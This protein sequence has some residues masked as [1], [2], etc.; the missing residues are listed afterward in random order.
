MTG[1]V[2]PSAG[3]TRP[4]TSGA[5]APKTVGPSSTPPRISPMTGG[6]RYRA[7]SW[8]HAWAATSNAD[9]ARSSLAMSALG[10]DMTLDRLTVHAARNL[11]R[12]A[13]DEAAQHDFAQAVRRPLLVG[14]AVDDQLGLGRHAAGARRTL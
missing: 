5:S 10:S 2:G 4:A 7:S 6:C 3:K 9:S 1:A 14:A 12:S 13:A 11:H 8:P